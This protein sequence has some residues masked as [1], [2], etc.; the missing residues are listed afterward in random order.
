MDFDLNDVCYPFIH[1]T[2]GQGPLLRR[3]FSPH[4]LRLVNH[5]ST[6]RFHYYIFLIVIEMHCY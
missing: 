5:L 2:T 6:F 1:P 3:K 4:L